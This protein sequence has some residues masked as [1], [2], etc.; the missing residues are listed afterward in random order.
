MKPI[1]ENS[2]H[3]IRGNVMRLRL[4]KE[5]DVVGM[6][7]W[8]HDMNLGIVDDD[9]NYMGTVSLKNIDKKCKMLNLR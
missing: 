4:L 6:L 3:R 7:E 5:K 8:M 9:D 1:A 2:L